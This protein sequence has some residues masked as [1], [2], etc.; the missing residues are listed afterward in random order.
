[1]NLH[2]LISAV[3]LVSLSIAHTIVGEVLV[4]RPLDRA[5]GLPGIR[6]SVRTMRETLRFAWHVTSVLGVGVAAVLLH[7]ARLT[8][9]DGDSARVVRIVALTCAA[10]FV[11]ALVG[12]RGR[13]PSWVVFL[14]VAILS[15]LG[16]V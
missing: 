5:T 16:S 1:M 10:S 12:S 3:L 2:L 4:L 11:V 9:L 14:V 6:G 7:C 15:W 8:P 13:H